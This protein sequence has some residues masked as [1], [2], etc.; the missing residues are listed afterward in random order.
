MLDGLER[1][2]LIMPAFTCFLLAHGPL[3]RSARMRWLMAGLTINFKIYLIGSI[4]AYPIKRRWRWFEGAIL[5]TVSVYIISWG[6]LGAG[7][8]AELVQNLTSWNTQ[9]GSA[10]S[11]LDLWYAT[12]FAPVVAV[13]NN[14]FYPINLELGSWPPE[15]FGAHLPH[16]VLFTQ[17][18]IVAAAATAWLR[19]EVIPTYRLVNFATTIALVTIEPGGYAQAL[20][21][22][23]TFFEPWRSGVAVRIALVCC[24]LLAIPGDILLGPVLPQTNNG[25]L[26]TG[27]LFYSYYIS[28]G[29][30]FRPA[31]VIVVP[32]ALSCATFAAVWRDIR[33]QGWRGRWRFSRDLPIMVGG[34][35]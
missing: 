6:L 22:L 2:N 5:A 27:P 4:F 21:M 7:T 34:G 26:N 33:V 18:T 8:P 1:G 25:F 31:F 3:L 16:L 13:L 11:L 24:Y 23:L 17:L 28:L 14:P 30:F 20:M 15:F 32:I 35:A 12:S 19:P 9:V 10:G 29:P